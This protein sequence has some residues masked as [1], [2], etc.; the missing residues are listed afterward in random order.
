MIPEEN[1][2]DQTLN[3]SVGKSKE[4][5]TIDFLKQQNEAQLA[6]IRYLESKKTISGANEELVR[7]IN[8]QNNKIAKMS[9]LQSKITEQKKN[10]SIREDDMK[11]EIS[12]LQKKLQDSR[13]KYSNVTMQLNSSR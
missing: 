12:T 1:V 10:F 6:K 2:N 9:Q 8:I 3:Q 4:Q 13:V 11:E 5:I 7:Q